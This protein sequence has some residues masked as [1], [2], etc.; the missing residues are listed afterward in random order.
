MKTTCRTVLLALT[1]ASLGAIAA[2]ASAEED[3]AAWQTWRFSNPGFGAAA[4]IEQH[5]SD[6]AERDSANVHRTNLVSYEQRSRNS[7]I[8]D[9][10]AQ[11]P[12]Q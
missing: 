11:G 4:G 10:G 8:R 2:P 9:A 6:Y 7:A 1:V 12:C 3:P 5:E